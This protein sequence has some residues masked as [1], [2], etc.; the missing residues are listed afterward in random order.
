MLQRL[1]ECSVAFLLLIPPSPISRKRRAD[2]H[3]ID[4][5]EQLHPGIAPCERLGIFREKF[6]EIRILKIA[7]PVENSKMAEIGDDDNP[8]PP[9]IP[10][11][12]VGEFP[13]ILFM[14]E[15]GLM[16]GRPIA[17]EL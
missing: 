15:P 16:N 11:R 9:Y 13:I 5:R 17:Q 14:T 12:Q 10:E 4:R 6:W 2:G 8:A 1:D 7:D 3:L